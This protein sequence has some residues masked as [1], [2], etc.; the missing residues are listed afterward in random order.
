M[1]VGSL[2]NDLR[3]LDYLKA[4]VERWKVKER[5]GM[6]LGETMFI[7]GEGASLENGMLFLM[8]TERRS[9]VSKGSWEV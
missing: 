5:F 2:P 9:I 4:A 6:T 1:C 3:L 7:H 8:G